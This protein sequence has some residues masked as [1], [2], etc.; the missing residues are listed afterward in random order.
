MTRA[1]CGADCKCELTKD[2]V[3]AP[4]VEV[5]TWLVHLTRVDGQGLGLKIKTETCFVVVTDVVSGSIAAASG[6]IS[7]NDYIL[8]VRFFFFWRNSFVVRY[9]RFQLVFSL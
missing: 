5:T 1:K 7:A 4:A 8:K 2:E 9:D 6:K 3:A